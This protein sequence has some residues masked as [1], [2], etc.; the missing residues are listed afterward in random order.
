[1]TL[2]KEKKG[3]FGVQLQILR[4]RGAAVENSDVLELGEVLDMSAFL[5]LFCEEST[6][7]YGNN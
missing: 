1:M 4:N 6:T 3:T 5:R 7:V 2:K